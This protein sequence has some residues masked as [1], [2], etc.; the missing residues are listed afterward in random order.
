[1]I[2]ILTKKMA[3]D[4]PYFKFNVSEFLL[5]RISSEKPEI[6]GMFSVVSAHY[7]HKECNITRKELEKKVKKSWVKKLLEKDYIVIS[8]LGYVIL[9]FL[10]EQR[11]DLLGT[12]KKLS[13]GGK[14]GMENRYKKP[15]PD[16]TLIEDKEKD[17]IRERDNTQRSL[18]ESYLNDLE[19]ST[20]LE[21]IARNLSLS[22]DFVKSKIPDFR[23]KADLTYPT[24]DR[25]INHFKN[26]VAKNV[27]SNTTREQKSA[28]V[29]S[30]KEHYAGEIL[31]VD[32][33]DHD[34]GV[35]QIHGPKTGND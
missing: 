31:S 3:K 24:Y 32:N 30:L 27:S 9:P 11:V 26:F 7:W 12:K 4:L 5:G 18:V 1:M 28:G 13:D 21:T 19:N 34:T 33:T 22:L 20:Y 23:V 25:F 10:D 8:E 2:N 15:N 14:K 29:S 17:K 16:I 6:I 35:S